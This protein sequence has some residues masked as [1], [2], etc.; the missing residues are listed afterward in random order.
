VT[1]FASRARLR[2]ALLTAW[3]A[4]HGPAFALRAA[5]ADRLLVV[6]HPRKSGGGFDLGARRLAPRQRR[7]S[8]SRSTGTSLTIC[9]GRVQFARFEP[10]AFSEIVYDLSVF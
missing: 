3:I 5:A 1:F 10:I 8:S 2:R 7:F 6:Q 4:E 9:I